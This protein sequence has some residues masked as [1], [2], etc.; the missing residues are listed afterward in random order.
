MNGKDILTSAL[1]ALDPKLHEPLKLVSWGR[2]IKLRTDLTIINDSASFFRT[3]FGGVG[4]QGFNGNKPWVNLN[5]NTMPDVFANGSKVTGAIRMLGRKLHW[6][7]IELEKAY[8]VGYPLDTQKVLAL[9]TMYNF[10]IDEQVYIGDTALGV[11][12]LVNSSVVT[13]YG[14]AQQGA[15]TTKFADKTA[16]QIL[17]D[18]NEIQRKGWEATSLSVCPNKILL[19]PVQF[20]ALVSRKVGADQNISI[21]EYLKKN[22]LCLAASG[23]ALDI[24]P[25]KWLTGIGAGA[26]DRMVAY[27]NSEDYVRFPLVPLQRREIYVLSDDVYS[28][29]LWA[30]GDVEFIYPETV[31]YADGI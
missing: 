12:G 8:K 15:A 19:P 22:A 3:D 13:S 26:T 11:K 18:I 29:Y 20:A 24:Q 5:S 21:M 25:C 16:D 9:R 27:T 17:Y 10:G 6:N 28:P 14:V 2:D 23:V 4:S 7:S 31:I 30:M 1:E